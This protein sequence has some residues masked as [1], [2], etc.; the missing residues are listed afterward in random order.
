[1]TLSQARARVI[2][3]AKALFDGTLPIPHGGYAVDPVQLGDLGEALDALSRIESDTQVSHPAS[4]DTLD[5]DADVCPNCGRGICLCSVNGYEDSKPQ[6]VSP[7]FLARCPKCGWEHSSEYFAVSGV[8]INTRGCDPLDSEAA[9]AIADS[10]ALLKAAYE[11]PADVCECGKD[12]Y[13]PAKCGDCGHTDSSEH[14]DVDRGYDDSSLVCRKCGS[15]N[16]STFSD[17]VCECGHVKLMHSPL[18]DGELGCEACDC[19]KFKQ[20]GGDDEQAST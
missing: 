20:K 6:V 14:F 19:M 10:A 9:K 7:H 11:K 18:V 12:R 16:V 1:M 4:N 8:H 3:A 13:F 17:D 2:Q 5:A 15:S